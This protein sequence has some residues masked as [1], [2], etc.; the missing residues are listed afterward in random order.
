MA[1]VTVA[2]PPTGIQGEAHQVCETQFSAGTCR[3]AALNGAK[4]LKVYSR[5]SLRSQICIEE[6]LVSELVVSVVVDVLGHVLIEHG[7]SCGEGWI[8]AS[9][10]DFT[11]LNP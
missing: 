2:S 11:V 7:K 3:A 9:A 5:C 6:V 10:R 4:L 8:A 1:I